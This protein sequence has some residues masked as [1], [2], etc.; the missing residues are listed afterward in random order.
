MEFMDRPKEGETSPEADVARTRA[1]GDEAPR[2]ATAP[3]RNRALRAVDKH[4]RSYWMRQSRTWI[5]RYNRNNPPPSRGGSKDNGH[6][7][8]SKRARKR[9]GDGKSSDSRP[10]EAATGCEQTFK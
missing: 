3:G 1:D 5:R 2:L 4:R 7:Q 9:Y 6:A 8:S 10:H